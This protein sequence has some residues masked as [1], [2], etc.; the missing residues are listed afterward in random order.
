MMTPANYYDSHS[1]GTVTCRLCPH[2]CVIKPGKSGVC[3]I[4]T[5]QNG[6]L[7]AQAY[8]QISALHFDP[9]EKKPLYHF[10]PGRQVLSV[11][12][13]G[14]NLSCDFCQNCEISQIGVSEAES[15]RLFSPYELLQMAQS[16]E[17]NLGIAFTYNE[18]VI[19]FEFVL[20][21][22]R[23]FKQTGLHTILVTNGFINEAPLKELLPFIDAFNVDLKAFNDHFYKQYAKAGFEPVLN[24][25]ETIYDAG[26]H[27]EITHLLIPERN[28]SESDFRAMTEWIA[29][30]LG[31]EVVLHLSR[32]FPAHKLKTKATSIELLQRFYRIAIQNLKYVYLGN[33]QS[34]TG[35]HTFCPQC[36]ALLIERKGYQVRKVYLDSDWKCSLCGY[37]L[38]HD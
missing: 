21:T 26:K 14:C 8:G 2:T 10:Y 29:D 23:L 18:P 13:V 22:A 25:L 12:S 27:L 16:Q 4:R 38:H 20:E 17:G 7:V 19:N 5:L 9:I 37:D 36:K 35:L 3:R 1:D 33:V 31:T 24:A 34:E 30:A 11:G 6:Q 28:D 15:L 32:Y